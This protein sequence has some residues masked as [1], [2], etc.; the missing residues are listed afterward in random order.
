MSTPVWKFSLCWLPLKF[1]CTNCFPI[2]LGSQ[3]DYISKRP[4]KLVLPDGG[5]DPD[6]QRG[7]LDLT[8]KRIQGELTKWKQVY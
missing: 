4:L 6:P 7:F 5:S 3:P 1:K 2:L 8:Q